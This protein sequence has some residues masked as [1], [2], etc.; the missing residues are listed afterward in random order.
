MNRKNVFLSVPRTWNK[1]LSNHSPHPLPVTDEKNQQSELSPE[2]PLI[3]TEC[4]EIKRQNLKKE[5]PIGKIFQKQKI[6]I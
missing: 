2:T 3:K 1:P 4:T 6:C 5:P